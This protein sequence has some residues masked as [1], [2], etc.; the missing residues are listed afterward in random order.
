MRLEKSLTWNPGRTAWRVVCKR[1]LWGPYC[2]SRLDAF[3][4]WCKALAHVSL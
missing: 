2:Y 1:L 4:Q 3:W